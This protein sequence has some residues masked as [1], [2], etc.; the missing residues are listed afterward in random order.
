MLLLPILKE[1]L[2]QSLF[3][4]GG[5]KVI[6]ECEKTIGIG[7]PGNRL[8]GSSTLDGGMDPISNTTGD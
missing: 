3:H 5:S 4:N 6:R 8:N 1:R 2:F 7:S